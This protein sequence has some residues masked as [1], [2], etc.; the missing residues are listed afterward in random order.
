MFPGWQAQ[1]YC[2]AATDPH[3]TLRIVQ[4]RQ[5]EAAQQGGKELQGEANLHNENLF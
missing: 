5:G 1:G 3:T 4:L 2:E